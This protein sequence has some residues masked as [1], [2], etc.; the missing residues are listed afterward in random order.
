MAEPTAQ[1]KD[2]ILHDVKQMVG[3]EWDDT[4]YDLDIMTHINSVFFDLDQI[5]VGPR[6][7]YQISGPEDKWVDYV[8]GVKNLQAVKSYIYIRV[9]LLFDPP[10]NSFLVTNLQQ[11]AD[12]M[13]W[14]LM[15][16]VDAPVGASAEVPEDTISSSDIDGL[17]S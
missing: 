14:R 10:T 17:F 5:G 13:E 12:K 7:G 8:G 11:Q 4:S 1:I 2:S 3:Q 16:E 9:R 6:G 15:V